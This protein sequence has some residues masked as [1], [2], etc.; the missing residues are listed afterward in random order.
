M[1][2]GEAAKG[3]WRSKEGGLI[4]IDC[5]TDSHLDNTIKMLSRWIES[6][7]LN[8]IE[9]HSEGF[10]CSLCEQIKS[11]ITIWHLKRTELLNEQ[12]RRLSAETLKKVEVTL[13]SKLRPSQLLTLST[14]PFKGVPSLTWEEAQRIFGVSAPVPPTPR[15][16]TVRK[17]VNA[18]RDWYRM[19]VGG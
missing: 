3:L 16:L 15:A 19:Q 12:A 11:R 6:D 1:I 17:V 2:R 5:M 14:T 7:K 8:L 18:A 13:N 9:D 4:A 10:A